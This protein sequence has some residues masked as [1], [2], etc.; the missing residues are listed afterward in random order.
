MAVKIRGVTGVTED[1]MNDFKGRVFVIETAIPDVPGTVVAICP[2]WVTA[3]YWIEE[4]GQRTPETKYERIWELH[5]LQATTMALN[6]A[7]KK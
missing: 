7:I 1:V 4:Q 5:Y 2:T 6:V 3:M